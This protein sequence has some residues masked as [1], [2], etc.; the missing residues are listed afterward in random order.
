[1]FHRQQQQQQ[2]VAK[3]L[4]EIERENEQ[5]Q[6]HNGSERLNSERKRKCANVGGSK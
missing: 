6:I 3:R 1:V 5:W 2:I 4:E